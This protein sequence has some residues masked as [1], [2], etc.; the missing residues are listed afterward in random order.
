MKKNGERHIKENEAKI[1]KKDVVA[2]FPVGSSTCTPVTDV[3]SG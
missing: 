1:E 3:I 2:K